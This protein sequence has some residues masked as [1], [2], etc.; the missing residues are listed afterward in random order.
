M[1]FEWDEARRLSNLAKHG[2]DFLD[3]DLLFDG[4]VLQA[5][6]RTVQGEQRWLATGMIDG[7]AVT[8]IFTRRGEV[9]RIISLRSAR[10]AE[11]ARYF[12]LFQQ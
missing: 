11:R 12:K 2:L 10:H 3:V 7:F 6:A 4:P 9:L 8:V 1:N 5:E